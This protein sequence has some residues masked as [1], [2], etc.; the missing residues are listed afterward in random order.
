MHKD[1]NII[2]VI[3]LVLVGFDL[4]LWS[5]ILFFKDEPRV[6]FLDVGQ[7]DSSLVYLDNILFLI[8]AG[9]D[10]KVLQGLSRVFPKKVNYIDLAFISHPQLDH[11][12]GF[13]DL[14]NKYDFGAF[15]ING[16][17]ADNKT[18]EIYNELILKI[19]ERK[20][21][22]IT[23]G[24]NDKIK[25]KNNLIEIISPDQNWIQSAELNDTSLVFRAKNPN[26]SILFTGDGGN[27]LLNYLSEKFDL[28]S[29][30]LKIPHHGSKYSFSE[31]FLKAT[32]PNLALIGVGIKNRYNHPSKEFIDGLN[33]LNT[34]FF[35]TDLAGNIVISFKNNNFF[36][37]TEK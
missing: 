30:I 16:R 34:P 35:R 20:I 26:F 14:L 23:L 17:E 37:K 9:P 31:K 12:G 21:P 3:F 33:N 4:F 25:Y 2:L 29:N 5:Q 18:H 13:L 28:K 24:A 32:S 1:K 19:E 10:K 36:V 6:Y 15:I 27:N 22:V 11:F 8:D 7:G